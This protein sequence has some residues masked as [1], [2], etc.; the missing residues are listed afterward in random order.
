MGKDEETTV[1]DLKEIV[2]RFSQ[3]RD[4]DQFHNPKDLAIG[5]VT[6]GSELLEK[7]RFKSEA[8][9]NALL[10]ST[11]SRREINEELSDILYFVLRFAQRYGIDLSTE[12]GKKVKK[13]A[14]RYPIEK[15]K[16]SNKKYSEL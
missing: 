14:A 2:R 12:L 15:A 3:E 11:S 7:F 13:N 6:E 9:A 5:I 4:W 8:Q 1:T 16:G 10:N